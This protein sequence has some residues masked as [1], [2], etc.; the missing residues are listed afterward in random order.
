MTRTLIF[1]TA[2]GPARMEDMT[3]SLHAVEIEVPQH[4]M[5]ACADKYLTILLQHKLRSG[6]G[7]WGR[8]NVCGKELEFIGG[9]L[10]AE[11]V[12][13]VKEMLDKDIL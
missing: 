8:I 12:S 1:K 7:E 2:D 4:I 5:D 9:S 3:Y 11:E 6:E 13:R 10:S